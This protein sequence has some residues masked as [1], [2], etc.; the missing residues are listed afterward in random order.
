MHAYYVQMEVPRGIDTLK[1]CILTSIYFDLYKVLHISY[2]SIY[3]D[4]QLQSITVARVA[5]SCFVV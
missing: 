4:S 3:S 1:P 5:F 2:L